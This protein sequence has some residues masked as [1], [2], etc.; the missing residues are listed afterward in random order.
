MHSASCLQNSHVGDLNSKSI[1]SHT[2]R[3]K[4]KYRLGSD[5]FCLQFVAFDSGFS[6]SHTS[7]SK[8]TLLI[9]QMELQC[10][11]TLSL[12]SEF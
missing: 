4:T 10:K 2:Q 3:K 9:L 6:V 1:N 5:F 7:C 11:A 12:Q 8:N